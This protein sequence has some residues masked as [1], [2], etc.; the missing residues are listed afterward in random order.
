ML[1][2]PSP[3]R[4]AE[5]GPSKC[6]RNKRRER[7][8]GKRPKSQQLSTAGRGNAVL[9]G[10]SVNVCYR[11]ASRAKPLG[12]MLPGHRARRARCVLG[13]GS[14]SAPPV[15]SSQLPPKPACTIRARQLEKNQARRQERDLK[16]S[17]GNACLLFYLLNINPALAG[18]E[19]PLAA[20]A[21]GSVHCEDS[22][23]SLS[24][25]MIDS[26]GSAAG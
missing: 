23:S 9:Q 10:R 17:R 8:W 18:C 25:S 14:W 13:K 4:Q 7:G 3:A 15:H 21:R 20:A 12:R 22:C 19:F 26:P 11:A 16:K 24:P 1:L 2:K 5:L 6:H